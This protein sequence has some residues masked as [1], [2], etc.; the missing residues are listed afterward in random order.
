MTS[1]YRHFIIPGA[2]RSATTFLTTLL[3]EHPKISMA[4]PLRPEPKFF[5]KDDTVSLN[6]SAYLN[7]HFSKRPKTAEVLGEKSTSYIERADT[8]QRIKALLPEVKLIFLFRNPIVRAISNY[9]FSYMNGYEK[10]DIN[11]A[12]LRE[13]NT[14]EAVVQSSTSGTS[15]SPQNYLKRGRYIDFLTPFLENFDRSNMLFILTEHLISSPQTTDDVFAFLKLEP[16]EVNSQNRLPIN[17]SKKEKQNK[18]NPSTLDALNDYFQTPNHDL[19]TK[20][21]VDISS[22]RDR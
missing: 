7:Q 1:Q 16:I 22:W 18:I 4:S 6:Y 17:M 21:G 15:V 3:M 9:H 20:L 14:P 8:A 12:L 5:M 2:Q 13:I 10:D 11:T 19:A